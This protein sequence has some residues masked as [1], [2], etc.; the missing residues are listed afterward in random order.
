M[1]HAG[2]YDVCEHLTVE[3][4]LLKNKH[5]LPLGP[6]VSK[7]RVT[8]EGLVVAREE[9]SSILSRARYL[10]VNAHWICDTAN[11]NPLSHKILS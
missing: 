1:D 11:L 9:E 3:D 6:A 2:E 10:S 4:G 5:Q 8:Y 7:R